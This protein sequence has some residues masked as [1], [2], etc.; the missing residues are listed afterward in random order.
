[1]SD[2]SAAAPGRWRRLSRS[3]LLHFILLGT[4]LFLLARM[5]EAPAAGPTILISENELAAIEAE[6][7]QR[8]GRPADVETLDALI[9][10]RVDDELL[11]HEARTLGWHRYDAIVQRRLL[12]NQRFLV[13]DLTISDAELLERAYTQGMDES[14]V[15]VRRRLLE[16]MRLLVATAARTPAPTD[17]E[18]AAWLDAHSEDFVQP[19]RIRLSHVFL[20]RDRRGESLTRDAEAMAAELRDDAAAPDE[21]ESRGDPFLLPSH[22]PMWSE[23]SIARQLGAEFSAGA[24]HAPLGRWSDPIGSS[25]GRHVVWVHEE[26][27]ARMPELDEV[28][29]SLT[30]D[31]LRDRER[32]AMRDHLLRLRA[33]ARI[34]IAR[35]KDDEASTR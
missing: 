34:E 2:T 29:R 28:R 31:V 7:L 33:T 9:A 22:L 6:W 30:A 21:A 23:D 14:D 12:R 5:G 27:P 15:V 26:E 24:M 25:Y 3:P 17:V 4:A 1:M 16:R 8:M 13:P 35:G 20:S 11:L 19:P 18:L 10:S 32:A